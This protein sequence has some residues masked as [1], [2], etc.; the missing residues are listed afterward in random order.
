LWQSSG[1]GAANRYYSFKS[2]IR[3]RKN[4]PVSFFESV[5][6]PLQKQP[7]F[8]MAEE[9]VLAASAISCFVSESALTF[10]VFIGAFQNEPA[11]R[12]EKLSLFV[13]TAFLGKLAILPQCAKEIAPGLLLVPQRRIQRIREFGT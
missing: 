3:W 1:F 2:L 4:L 13:T 11:T 12:L 7:H 8:F 6:D 10:S 9:T 5:N